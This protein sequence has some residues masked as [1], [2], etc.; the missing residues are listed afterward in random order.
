MQIMYFMQ[1]ILMFHLHFVR[2]KKS[3]DSIKNVKLF[4]SGFLHTIDRLF[5]NLPFTSPKP[6]DEVR[7]KNNVPLEDWNKKWAQIIQEHTIEGAR[8]QLLTGWKSWLQSH[9]ES[10]DHGSQDLIREDPTDCYVEDG[11]GG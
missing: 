6:A 5:W 10:K 2:L 7:E 3:D 8:G 4:D 11:P 9:P 1:F